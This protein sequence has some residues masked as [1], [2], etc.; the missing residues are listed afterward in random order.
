M[1]NKQHEFENDITSQRLICSGA[2]DTEKKDNNLYFINTFVKIKD[3]YYLLW[4]GE[5]ELKFMIK[6]SK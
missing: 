5:K 4:K 6:T 2:I 1:M 3:N